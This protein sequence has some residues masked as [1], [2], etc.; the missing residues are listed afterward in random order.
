RCRISEISLA[1][2]VMSRTPEVLQV[3]TLVL[4]ALIFMMPDI[5]HASA[6]ANGGADEAV[7]YVLRYTPGDNW[8]EGTP[9]DEQPGIEAHFEYLGKLFED[10]RLLMG[11]RI[12]DESTGLMILRT[13]SLEEAREVVENDP[14]VVEGI[15]NAT[16]NTWDVRM[17]SMRW[18]RRRAPPVVQ[19]PDEPWHLKRIDPSAP[20]TLE[21]KP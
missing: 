6:E 17:S 3:K 11:G 7:Y 15:V 16:V 13:G 12:R 8:A 9:Y 20:I 4:I 18:T 21:E 5:G 14:G 10:R 19:D 1:I 2:S